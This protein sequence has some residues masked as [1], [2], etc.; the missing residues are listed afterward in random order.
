MSV[1][2]IEA[3]QRLVQPVIVQILPALNRGGVERGTVEVAAA[4]IEAG[5]R[6]VVISHGGYFEA[7]LKRIGA[8]HYNLPV[9]SKNPLGWGATR[10]RVKQILQD[11]HADLV[12]VRS[13]VPSW[14]ALPIAKKL[15]IPTVATIHSKFL[16]NNFIKHRYNAKMLSA[17]R[18][19]SISNYVD[20]ILRDD[21]AGY[22]NP[23]KNRV[24]HRGAD[25]QLFDPDAV[26]QSRVIRAAERM[27]VSLDKP[28]IML[29]AR[30]TSWKGHELLMDAMALREDRNFC[31][32][33]LGVD[34][35]GSGYASRLHAKALRLGLGGQ[36]RLVAASDDMPAALMLADVVVMP[37]I[38]PEPFGRVAVEAQA[39]GRPVVSFDHGGAAESIIDGKTGWRAVPGDHVS[40]AASIEK[41]LSLSPSAR[42]I[43][44]KTARAHVEA[45]FSAKKMCDET[46]ALYREL[47]HI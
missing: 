16:A 47:L 46:L 40:L 43:L 24:I 10:R 12:H 21:Y 25:L 45:N 31:L 18:V 5:W 30:A 11:E 35:H 37:S 9:Q 38:L 1:K 3:V 26:N 36:V 2:K 17:D 4:I 41:A 23:D 42:D 33:L 32:V 22:Y 13:R 29:P 39:M 20:H 7:Q 15:K 28:I 44:A 34:P 6:A 8:V 19:I 27:N 14:I